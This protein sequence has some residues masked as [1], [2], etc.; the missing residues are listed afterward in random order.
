MLRRNY[1]IFPFAAALLLIGCATPPVRLQTQSG[2]PE[3]V[4]PNVSKKQVIE[5]LVASKLEKGMQIRSVTEFGV[6]VVKRVENSIGA[7]LLYGSRYDSVPE[8]RVHYNVVEF[9]PN[10]KVFSTAQMVTNP[11]SSFE[12]A[13]DVT[14]SVAGQM[15]AE[16]QDLQASFAAHISSTSSGTAPAAD[17]T[18]PVTTPPSE[19]QPVPP[20]S[21]QAQIPSHICPVDFDVI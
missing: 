3:I 11:G 21:P 6:V 13:S 18:Q 20:Q 4:I 17:K 12:R 16:L 19:T 8:A 9:G 1:C 15:Q 10:V 2:N 7:S 5:K 14:A